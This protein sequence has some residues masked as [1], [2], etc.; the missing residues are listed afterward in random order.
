MHFSAESGT[1]HAK[2]FAEVD[3]FLDHNELGLAYDYL[4]SLARESEWD[5]LALLETLLLAAHN[6]GEQ[7]SAL[8]LQARI[9][10]LRASQASLPQ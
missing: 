2:W 5:C 4:V 8:S 6:M 3:H 9:D 7:D 1:R 10:E